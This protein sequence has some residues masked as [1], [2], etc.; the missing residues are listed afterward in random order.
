M[1]SLKNLTELNFPT[2]TGTL[3]TMHCG[4]VMT[5]GS[6]LPAHL[7]TKKAQDTS[8]PCMPQ[9]QLSTSQPY[10]T[11]STSPILSMLLSGQLP[12]APFLGANIWARPWSPQ[13]PPL[14]VNTMS[15]VPPQSLSVNFTMVHALLNFLFL[16]WKLPRNK[17]LQ[18]SSQLETIS[19][20][21][22]LP[23]VTI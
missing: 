9:Y 18:L 3:S 1:I 19:S 8:V 11:V 22:V 10:T 7:L 13:P 15:F 21:H 14:M 5:T 4:M 6:S 16:G 12:P 2:T 20:A 23:S 17:E